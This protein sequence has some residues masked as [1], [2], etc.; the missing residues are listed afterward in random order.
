MKVSVIKLAICVLACISVSACS[1]LDN[2][3]KADYK[4][5]Q[6]LPPL[7]VPPDLMTTPDVSGSNTVPPQRTTYSE[8]AGDKKTS[9]ANTSV[10][11]PPPVQGVSLERDGA[12]RW[13]VV[14]ASPE[15]LWPYLRQ[16]LTGLGL[17]IERENA[18]TG[19]LETDWLDRPAKNPTD[20]ALPTEWLRRATRRDKLRLRM[21]R[22]TKPG[23]TEIYISHYGIEAAPDARANTSWQPRPPE[24]DI[25]AEVLRLLMTYLG[26]T[27]VQAKTIIAQAGTPA[28]DRAR[29]VNRGESYMLNLD[30]A[31]DRAWRRVGLS[32]DRAGFTVE[33]RDR[34]QGVYYVR[35]LDPDKQ[36]DKPGWF[37]KL[38]SAKD[39]KSEERYQIQLQSANSGT[40]VVVKTNDGAPEFGNTSERIL[41]L[42]YEQ[43]K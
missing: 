22:G 24:P 19:V 36:S 32:L 7:E 38:F 6:Q 43:L 39:K 4:N 29:L 27:D 11:V 14:Q 5:A 34:S 21:E 30:D 17:V 41:S 18:T 26:K 15:G 9:N 8:V 2:K 28:V 13:L 25:E 20:V 12:T 31:L 37:A 33:D 35:Y 23:T 16:F 3:R 10:V 42:L 1:F 40:Q